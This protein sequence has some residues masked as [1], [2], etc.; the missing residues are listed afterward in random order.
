MRIHW[1]VWTITAGA[2]IGCAGVGAAGADPI[3]VEPQVANYAR[4]AAP[5]VC[6]T[7]DAYPTLTGVSAVLQGIKDDTGFTMA[8]SAQV[9]VLSV[10]NKCPRHLPLLQRYASTYSPAPGGVSV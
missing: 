3:Q 9:L 1:S 6:G 5:A 10:E 4:T 7:L 8:Q 2:L